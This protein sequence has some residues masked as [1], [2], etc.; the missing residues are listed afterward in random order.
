MLNFTTAWIIPATRDTLRHLFVLMYGLG[1]REFKSSARPDR[2]PTT[3]DSAEAGLFQPR[4]TRYG[5]PDIERCAHLHGWPD[6]PQKVGRV[7]HEGGASSTDLANYGSGDGR[8]HIIEGVA[9]AA[10]EAARRHAQIG[11]A[12]GHW[13]P[14]PEERS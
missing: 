2:A 8:F 3:A 7:F 10:V 9:D 14:P 4:T 11:G 1:M 12:D 6:D 5:C 13:G